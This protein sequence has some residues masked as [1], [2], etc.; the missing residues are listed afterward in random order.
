VFVKQEDPVSASSSLGCG[1]QNASLSLTDGEPELTLQLLVVDQCGDSHSALGN[2]R[3]EAVKPDKMEETLTCIICQ[4]LL[5]DCVRYATRHRETCRSITAGSCR[6][7]RCGGYCCHFLGW[8]T[9][10]NPGAWDQ[11]CRRA[12]KA[13]AAT[14][15]VDTGPR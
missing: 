7:R 11:G 9:R 2:V 4:D 14:P 15:S 13:D 8:P 12:H 5:H 3:S 6:L 1:G 10:P